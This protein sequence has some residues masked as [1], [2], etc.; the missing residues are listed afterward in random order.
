MSGVI[1]LT[2]LLLLL[3][4]CYYL[5]L[6]LPS[7]KYYLL[8]YSRPITISSSYSPP[9][10]I[11]PYFHDILFIPSNLANFPPFRVTNLILLC[12]NP[13]S[14]SSSTTSL[15]LPPLPLPLL[16]PFFSPQSPLLQ[17]TGNASSSR[18][19]WRAARLRHAGPSSL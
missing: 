17:E 18:S 2:S 8:S 4:S 12:V 14:F 15:R 7:C 19:W 5:L 10:T 3:P 9:V 16:S 6:L 13:V 1:L 11:S